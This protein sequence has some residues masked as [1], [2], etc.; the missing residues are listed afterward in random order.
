MML[1]EVFSGLGTL[2]S[3][4]EACDAQMASNKTKNSCLIEVSP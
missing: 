1:F 2:T 3:S 4:A